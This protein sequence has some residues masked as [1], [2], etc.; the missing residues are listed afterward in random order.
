ML[1]YVVTV[2]VL[3]DELRPGEAPLRGVDVLYI[4]IYIYTHTYIHTYR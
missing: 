2:V 1:N 4:Y 3:V